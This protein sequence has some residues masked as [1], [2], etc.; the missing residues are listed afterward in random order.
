VHVFDPAAMENARKVHPELSYGTSPLDVARDA[1]VVVLLT[2]WTDFREIAPRQWPR[3]SAPGGSSTGGTPWTQRVAGRR[4]GVQGP[5]PT[6]T[7]GRTPHDQ[8]EPGANAPGSG[9]VR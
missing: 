1:D 2:E 6:L 7:A 8:P 4:L 3:S 5:R 9:K